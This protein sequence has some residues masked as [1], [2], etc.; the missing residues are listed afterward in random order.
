M[1]VK[2]ELILKDD[3][4]VKAKLLAAKEGLTLGKWL[5]KLIE[6]LP[7]PEEDGELAAI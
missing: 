1:A 6:G 4:W 5:N 7:E 2:Y 3:T